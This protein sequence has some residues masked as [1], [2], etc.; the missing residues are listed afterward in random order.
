MYVW[1][2]KCFVLYK[3]TLLLFDTVKTDARCAMSVS[4]NDSGPKR[5]EKPIDPELRPSITI[6]I[7]GIGDWLF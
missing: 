7:D 5:D 4:W 6:N 1:H 3:Q 2:I